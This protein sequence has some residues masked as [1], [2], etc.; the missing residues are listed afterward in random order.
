[1]GTGYFTIT[2]GK[3]ITPSGIIE[4]GSVT[5][6]NGLIAAVNEEVQNV[7]DLTVIDA[8]GMFISPVL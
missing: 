1:M 7:K 4:G 6:R 2:N 8:G 3:L 5:V